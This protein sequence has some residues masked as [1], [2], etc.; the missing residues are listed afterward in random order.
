MDMSEVLR[1]RKIQPGSQKFG[2]EAHDRLADALGG[3]GIEV[4]HEPRILQSLGV[5]SMIPDFV[6]TKDGK[7]IFI[8]VKRQ[9][10]KGNAHERVYKY[11]APRLQRKVT[12]LLKSEG[13]PV[14]VVLCDS[15]SSTPRY[16]SE[17]E[18]NLDP[19]SYLL[20]KNYD[21]T[22]LKDFI[23]RSFDSSG[24]FDASKIEEL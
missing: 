19:E 6:L 18:Q 2:K 5:K 9:G 11:F 1:G 17:F 21:V 22:L 23:D 7:S 13:Y 16:V 15:L 14:Y 4:V 12:E 3:S 10:D 20:W 24:T 8:E